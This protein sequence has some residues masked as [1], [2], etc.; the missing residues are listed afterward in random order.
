M[1]QLLQSSQQKDQMTHN[2][3][4]NNDKTMKYKSLYANI[5]PE[6]KIDKGQTTIT[7]SD[8]SSWHRKRHS[9]DLRVD[10]E[11]SFYLLAMTW[12]FR[13]QAQIQLPAPGLDNDHTALSREDQYRQMPVLCPHPPPLPGFTLIRA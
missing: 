2:G 8:H 5:S 13:S 7:K 11:V 9:N 1:K 3:N 12:P 6:I 4:R 10:D